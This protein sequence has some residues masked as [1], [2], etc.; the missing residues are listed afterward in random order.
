MCCSYKSAKVS[1]KGVETIVHK[2]LLCQHEAQFMTLIKF[3]SKQKAA[4]KEL[5]CFLTAAVS[6]RKHHIN[7]PGVVLVASSGR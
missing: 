2:R 4:N 1:I 7:L 3:I 5:A 6:T